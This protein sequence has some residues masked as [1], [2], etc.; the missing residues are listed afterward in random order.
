VNDSGNSLLPALA[1]DAFARQ[2][3]CWLDGVQGGSALAGS[4]DGVIAV[5]MAVAAQ[6]SIESGS[7]V[8][9]ADVLPAGTLP[10]RE[11]SEVAGGI[12]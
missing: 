3:D 12:R 9:L 1:G 7:P 10:E 5:A 6:R 11:P 8:P 2:L 4:D